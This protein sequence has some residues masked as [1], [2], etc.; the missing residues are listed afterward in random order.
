MSTDKFA[1]NPELFDSPYKPALD[2][3]ETDMEELETLL[4]RYSP[5]VKWEDLPSSV[6]EYHLQQARFE[7]LRD[8]CDKMEN[9]N[10]SEGQ[11]HDWITGGMYFVEDEV[12]EGID[13]RFY[14]SHF[15]LK[16]LNYKHIADIYG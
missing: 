14:S 2:A 11:N 10:M 13:V 6:Q 1:L 4:N 5:D 9:V 12:V 3:T 7:Q 15:V 16:L 8:L